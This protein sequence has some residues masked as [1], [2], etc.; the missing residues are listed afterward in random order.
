MDGYYL[1][2]MRTAAAAA[3]ASKFLARDRPEKVG[4][5]GAGSLGRLNLEAHLAQ[6]GTV[7]SVTVW[8]RTRKTLDSFVED[9]QSKFGIA[10]KPVTDARRAVEDSDVVYC[11]TRSR[12]PMYWTHG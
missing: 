2:Y 12:E 3:V 4:L 5:I 10:V 6:Y 7:E 11:A 1:S 9:V 8:S